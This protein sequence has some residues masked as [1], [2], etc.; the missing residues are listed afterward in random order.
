MTIAKSTACLFLNMNVRIL[1]R[2]KKKVSYTFA[3]LLHFD[4]CLEANHDSKSRYYL[5]RQKLSQ[6]SLP[7]LS[8][9]HAYHYTSYSLCNALLCLTDMLYVQELRYLLE[10]GSDTGSSVKAV[11][12]LIKKSRIICFAEMNC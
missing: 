8:E 11:L 1:G 3:S 9:Q 5:E 12:C 6:N 4:F 10:D 7:C 2:H